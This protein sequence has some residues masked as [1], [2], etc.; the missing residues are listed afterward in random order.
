MV[1]PCDVWSC[2]STI[3]HRK[4]HGGLT[5]AVPSLVNPT[6]FV[7]MPRYASNCWVKNHHTIH[8]SKWCVNIAW[9]SDSIDRYYAN[10]LIVSANRLFYLNTCKVVED[11]KL[12]KIVWINL[13]RDRGYPNLATQLKPQSHYSDNQSPTSD[14]HFFFG[15]LEELVILYRWQ[16][17]ATTKK[18]SG[19]QRLA[20]G[21]RYSVTVA[22][23]D[24]QLRA[25]RALLQLKDSIENQKV[26][27]RCTKSMA[28]APFWLTQLTN[29]FSR[30]V[31]TV[32][33]ISGVTRIFP[34]GS[35][36]CFLWGHKFSF[37][38]FT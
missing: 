32:D 18:K 33:V 7:H 5:L 14:N 31:I 12:L 29:C 8:E 35:G 13:L 19:C 3:D 6:D 11:W 4:T 30:F 23:E 1:W 2:L 9:P 22:L 36:S 15:W 16:S 38:I 21:C 10:L 26:H 25:R 28:I 34:G 27:Y 17:T 24:Y 37:V 20:T